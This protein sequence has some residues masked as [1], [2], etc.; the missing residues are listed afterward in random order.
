[1][2]K[3]PFL[4]MSLFRIHPACIF[5]QG[6]LRIDVNVSVHPNTSSTFGTRC[7]IKNLN[8]IRFMTQ[9]IGRLVFISPLEFLTDLHHTDKT[10]KSQDK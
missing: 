8:S 6:S 2:E 1:M 5:S 7:E 9:A 10:T 3:V 4:F